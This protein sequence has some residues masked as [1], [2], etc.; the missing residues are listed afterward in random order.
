M[1]LVLLPAVVLGLSFAD[2]MFEPLALLF[3][4]NHDPDVMLR[5][6]PNY[7]PTEEA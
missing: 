1:S 3:D 7:E 2:G 4:S 6:L 5:Q